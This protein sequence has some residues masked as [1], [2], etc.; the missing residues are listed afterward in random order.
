MPGAWS[1]DSQSFATYAERRATKTVAG[2]DRLLI[3]SAGSGSGPPQAFLIAPEGYLYDPIC[4]VS[5]VGNSFVLTVAYPP[6]HLSDG[7]HETW[8]CAALVQNGA[9]RPESPS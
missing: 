3:L 5:W 4:P 8:A 6:G 1:E 2:E 7:P 9:A